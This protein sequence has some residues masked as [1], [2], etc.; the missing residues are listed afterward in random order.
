MKKPSD[1][2]KD[3]ADFE[4]MFPGRYIKGV[5]VKA[6]GRPIALTIKRIEPRHE[7]AGKKGDTESKPAI[8]FSETEKGLVLNKTNAGSIAEVLG[9]DPRKWIGR[10]VVLCS[11]RGKF[12]GVVRDVVRI[13]TDETRAA[14]SRASTAAAKPSWDGLEQDAPVDEAELARQAAEAEAQS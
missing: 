6:A 5:E 7:L 4:L 8:F 3:Y 1:D 14:Q 13:D 2:I 11:E 10:K 9:R 12:G